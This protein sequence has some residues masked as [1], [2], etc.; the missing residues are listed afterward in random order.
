ME[1][2][3]ESYSLNTV[4]PIITDITKVLYENVP[5]LKATRRIASDADENS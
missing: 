5:I 1:D 3:P 4:Q 2:A